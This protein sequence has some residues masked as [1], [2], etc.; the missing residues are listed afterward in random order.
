MLVRFLVLPVG[1]FAFF[2]IFS[3]SLLF[4]F[5][6]M[7]P[8]V[9]ST[10][11][12]G[13]S[14]TP[15]EEWLCLLVGV[16]Q[17][18]GDVSRK[19][20]GRQNGNGSRCQDYALPLF[21]GQ[22]STW[23]AYGSGIRASRSSIPR[24]ISGRFSDMS[25][26]AHASLDFS[27]TKNSS[28]PLSAFLSSTLRVLDDPPD[29]I[30]SC[31]N[32]LRT[33][34]KEGVVG[35]LLFRLHFEFDTLEVAGQSD[36]LKAKDETVEKIQKTRNTK[37]VIWPI[38][39][40]VIKRHRPR[41]DG[42]T[43]LGHPFLAARRE[44][45]ALSHQQFQG[46]PNIVQLQAWGLCL[47]TIEN[48]QQHSLQVPLLVLERAEADLEQFLRRP[49]TKSH[50]LRIRLCRDIGNGLQILHQTGFTHG[51]LKPKN[52]LVFKAPNGWTAKLCDFGHAQSQE[53]EPPAN[54]LQG[55]ETEVAGLGAARYLGTLNWRPPEVA[56]KSDKTFSHKDL[57]RC[58]IFV[59]GMVVWSTLCKDGN[60]CTPAFNDLMDPEDTQTLAIDAIR[61]LRMSSGMFST[62]EKLIQECI[63][64][65]E[66]RSLTPWDNLRQNTVF[67]GVR[68]KV[69][70]VASTLDHH[71]LFP[72]TR[73]TQRVPTASD[74]F[75]RKSALTH[76]PGPNVCPPLDPNEK[77]KYKD[78]SWWTQPIDGYGTFLSP[79]PLL[80]PT[81]QNVRQPE[82]GDFRNLSTFH[83][84]RDDKEIK[85]VYTNIVSSLGRYTAFEV[86]RLYCCARFRSR[87]SLEEWKSPRLGLR[88][89]LVE[90][91]L[92][93]RP[94]P[95]I[96]TMAWLCRGEVGVH[97]VKSLPN[98]FTTWNAILDPNLLNESERLER[99]LLLLQSGAEIQTKLPCSP[100]WTDHEK[101]SI[102]FEYIRT[103]RRAVVG[104]VMKELLYQLETIENQPQISDDT[105]GYLTGSGHNFKDT[106]LAHFVDAVNYE[107]VLE[108]CKK[109]EPRLLKRTT[110][111]GLSIPIRVSKSQDY[112][113][114]HRQ[115][116]Q[117]ILKLLHS[118]HVKEPKQAYSGPSNQ[119]LS[120]IDEDVE[121]GDQNHSARGE[122]GPVVAGWEVVK[123]KSDGHE[124]FVYRDLVTP[125]IT[126]R[127]PCVNLLTGSQVRIGYQDG[128]GQSFYL[129]ELS[130]FFQFSS[131]AE[132]FKK[133]FP[134][135]S[136][137]WFK[138][139]QD[140]KVPTDDILG[141]LTDRWT[142]PSLT[143]TV[144]ITWLSYFF[145]M[146]QKVLSIS[147]MTLV[148]YGLRLMPLMALLVHKSK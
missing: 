34:I 16:L 67:S 124:F 144:D 146:W 71:N 13:T 41:R 133:R 12:Q 103:C 147:L 123:V 74:L 48:P 40:L 116:A 140:F 64:E 50:K 44:V 117:Q 88:K 75:T 111:F 26:T 2:A 38:D 87:L 118:P 15:L 137:E 97:E 125:S 25:S 130:F 136:E 60:S 62:I 3:S 33:L 1:I 145:S 101:R 82:D 129:R 42:Q 106:A 120:R 81:P 24:V 73:M 80:F 122:E 131:N 7:A 10:F 83:G 100:T 30:G 47:D 79:P 72:I 63:C 70:Q 54:T 114:R 39:S 36:V 84:R 98:D 49:T 91:A 113:L 105:K 22:V 45:L 43:Q 104:L 96:S 142:M 29:D 128:R 112:Q 138:G 32:L 27:Q 69:K 51:D 20:A 148:L 4:L 65:P 76:L 8:P 139:E 6:A 127:K 59:Y 28:Q 19:P 110:E 5:N 11:G 115:D 143:E 119:P 85:A 90:L 31:E 17:T 126:F 141:T 14:E 109:A 53:S 108:L 121:Q 46:H 57:Q 9:S 58:D 135:Y 23:A 66:K 95:E 56:R 94:L 37:N 107:A 68:G 35:P 92:T 61:D 134:M 55:G 52:V 86:V 77:R 89:N 78:Q 18:Q 99:F 21:S 132:A 102:L 93:S